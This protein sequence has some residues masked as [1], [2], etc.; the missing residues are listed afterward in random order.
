[1][2]LRMGFKQALEKLLPH[3]CP[4]CLLC[5]LSCGSFSSIED[6]TGTRVLVFPRGLS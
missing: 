4:L 2:G 1:M 5:S 6:A 3:S